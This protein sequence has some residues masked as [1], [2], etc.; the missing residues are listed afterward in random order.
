VRSVA[1]FGRADCDAAHRL[2]CAEGG[3][4]AVSVVMFEGSAERVG[5]GIG[6]TVQV[7]TGDLYE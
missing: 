6:R 3:A 4:P 1:A 2:A 7:Q 5:M